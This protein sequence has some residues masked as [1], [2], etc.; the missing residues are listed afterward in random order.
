[1]YTLNQNY[2]VKTRIFQVIVVMVVFFV[3]NMADFY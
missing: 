3:N 2:N 1:M